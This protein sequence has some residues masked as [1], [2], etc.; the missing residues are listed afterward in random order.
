MIVV[1]QRL[2]LAVIVALGITGC[3]GDLFDPSPGD[4]YGSDDGVIM[5]ITPSGAD[6][7]WD[8]AAGEITESFTTADDGSFD[9]EGTYTAGSGGPVQEDN[10]PLAEP[11]RYTGTKFQL[12]RITLTVEVPGS[13]VTLGPYLMR[14]G[15]GV[16]LNR[17][18]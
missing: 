1:F 10:P 17:C 15:Q 9:L 6:L 2:L 7:E 8:C 4:F 13:E 3:L 12:S 5:V 11:A 16:V 14:L 18:L